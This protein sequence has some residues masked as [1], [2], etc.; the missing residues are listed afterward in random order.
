MK[1]VIIDDETDICFI[2]AFE[3]KLKGFSPI[4]F[5]SA[6]EA[7]KYFETDTADAVIC[8]FQMPKMSGLEL[9]NWLQSRGVKVPFYILTGELNMD[10]LQLLNHGISDVL[11]KPHDLKKIPTLLNS[12]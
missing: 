11:Y 3:L 10:S 4:T 9:F 1:I 6:L 5:H 7:K 8:D 2:L 12:I